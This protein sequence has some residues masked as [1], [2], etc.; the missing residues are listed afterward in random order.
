MVYRARVAYNTTLTAFVTY[1]S[2]CAVRFLL[3]HAFISLLLR[4]SFFFS[5]NTVPLLPLPYFIELPFSFLLSLFPPY[6]TT[7]LSYIPLPIY[8][9]NTNRLALMLPLPHAWTAQ[10]KF[11]LTSIIASSTALFSFAIQSRHYRRRT[12][13]RFI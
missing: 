13:Q 10:P 7:L 5:L 8:A 4:P 6:C 9:N 12:R 1:L 2:A 3:R 11:V